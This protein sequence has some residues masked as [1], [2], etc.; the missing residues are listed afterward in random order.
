MLSLEGVSKLGSLRSVS[1]LVSYCREVLVPVYL[2]FKSDLL[3]RWTL[4][5]FSLFEVFSFI[6]GLIYFVLFY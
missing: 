3:G 6:K 2:N 1:V 5:T 4:S